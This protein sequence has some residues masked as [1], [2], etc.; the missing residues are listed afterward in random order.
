MKLKKLLVIIGIV[1]F[2]VV[3]VF[4]K[5]SCNKIQSIKAT[6]TDNAVA[7]ANSSVNVFASKITIYNGS[8]DK[9]RVILIKNGDGEWIL[10]GKFGLRARK[11]AVDNLLN[12]L[13]DLKGEV[14]AESK[15]LFSDFQIQDNE[16][17]HLI[18]AGADG[19]VLTHLV[20]SFKKLNGNQN[21]IRKF[22]SEI[23]TYLKQNGA[24]DRLIDYMLQTPRKK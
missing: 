10:E 3:L 19:S 17:A 7:L 16:S 18:L 2:L 8:D 1:S 14:R 6:A 15:S 12:S 24:S 11:E 5:N 20:I 22:N 9:K 4:I 21:F 23:I 13:Y